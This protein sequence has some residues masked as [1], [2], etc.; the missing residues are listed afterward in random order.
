MLSA[1]QS[2]LSVKS[3]KH[4]KSII[5]TTRHCS[6]IDLSSKQLIREDLSLK[7]YLYDRPWFV[8]A[9]GR[10]GATCFQYG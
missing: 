8:I 9:A 5:D 2:G 10:T 7:E 3:Y 6:L 1:N 4:M